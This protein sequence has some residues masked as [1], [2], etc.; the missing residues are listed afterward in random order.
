MTDLVIGSGPSGIS[1]AT[2]LL[3][4]GRTVLMLDGGKRLEPDRATARDQLAQRAPQDWTSADRNI[5]QAPQYATPTG[6]VRRYGSDFAMERAATTFA[7]G[8]D[9]FALRASRALGGLSNLWGS[10]VLPYRS[11]DMAGWAVTEDDL[12]P[13]YKA[14]AEFL[15]IAGRVD[16]LAGIF[17]ALS[18][19]GRTPLAPSPQAEVL[20][21]RLTASQSRLAGIGITAGAARHAV[22]SG[23]RECGMCLHGCPWG[24]IWSAGAAID[25]LRARPGFSYRPGAVVTSFA[26]TASGVSL[27]LAGGEALAGSRVFVA[28]G[29]LETARLV[30]ASRSG[31]GTLTLKDSQHGFLPALHLWRSG[32]RPDRGPFH[33]LTQAFLEINDTAISPYTVHAQ[34]YTWNAFFERDLIAS[35]GAR[36]PGSAPLWRALARRLIVAQVFL[37]SDHSARVTLS[38]AGNGRLAARLDP[39]PETPAIFAS[40]ASRLASGLKIAGLAPLTFARRLEAIG[41]SFHAGS[42]VPMQRNPNSQGSDI[43]GRPHGLQRV[44]LV[45]ASVLPAIPAT[46]ITLPVMANAHRIGTIS[47]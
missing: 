45:D 13:H 46:T 20:L 22:A 5:W 40:A 27:T 15:P 36:L 44:H 41:S 10:A 37:H 4:R 1:V 43:L 28:A 33:T 18:M 38:L 23:C 17:P 21:S 47:A 6:Q 30:L 39:N 25:Q 42:T 7:D 26:E 2:A 3:A 8:C 12:A 14:V 24:L 31:P 32:R 16:D 11:A 9:G 35:Y 34:I 19:Q 29:V